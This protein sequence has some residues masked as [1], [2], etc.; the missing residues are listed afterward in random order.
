MDILGSIGKLLF[1]TGRQYDRDTV[2]KQIDQANE[3][4]QQANDYYA[5]N[6]EGA[7]WGSL[8]PMERARRSA[9]MNAYNDAR[10]QNK[11]G[12]DALGKAYEQEE[13]D[14][15][16]K[17]L[18]NGLLGGIVNPMYQAGTA[19]GDLAMG[20]YGHSG[21]DPVSDIGAG[22]ETAMNIIPGASG[23]KAL[24]SAGKINKA[25]LLKN[26][27]AGGASSVANAYREGGSGTKVAEALGQLPTGLALGALAPLGIE[28]ATPFAKS[29]PGRLQGLRSSGWRNY[30]PKSGLGKLALGA[31]TLY[32]GSKLLPLLSGGGQNQYQNQYQDEDEDEY[33]GDY[34]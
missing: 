13:K 17:P 7:D 18:G 33:R 27:L 3:L 34:Y 23:A 10:S 1:G 2:N 6:I 4:N 24:T 16:F 11:K 19:I 12:L 8:S 28:K 26:A 31:G 5:K 25:N 15:R 29:I 21:R 30:L 32:G 20:S 22:V 9:I 14:W